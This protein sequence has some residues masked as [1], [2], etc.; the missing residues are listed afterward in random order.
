[1]VKDT[2]CIGSLQLPYVHDHDIPSH[3]LKRM[4]YPNLKQTFF[5]G[6]FIILQG[7]LRGHHGMVVGYT[8]TRDIIAHG[9]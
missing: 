9:Y 6:P 5:M 2:D 8:S 1:M 3:K 4:H 7:G